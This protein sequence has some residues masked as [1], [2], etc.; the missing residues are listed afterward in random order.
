MGDV[1]VRPGTS[2]DSG[3]GFGGGTS[4]SRTVPAS[5]VDELAAVPGAAR[6]DG[7]VTSFGTFVVSARTAS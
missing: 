5:L 6:A 3:G 4:G 1:I 7:R 2:A